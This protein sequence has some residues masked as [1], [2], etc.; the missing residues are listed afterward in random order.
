MKFRFLG[1]TDSDFAAWVE[2]NKA[3][4][5]TLDR[6]AYLKLE[7]PSKREPVRHFS[8]VESNLYTAVLNR[9]ADDA[10]MCSSQMMAIDAA[11]GAGKGGIPGMT[12]LKLPAG[13]R[14]VVA[15]MCTRKAT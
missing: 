8:A 7:T 11:G 4:G 14:K 13:D 5:Q 12:T 2:D 6:L 10:K 15:A 9:C 3:S 1:M